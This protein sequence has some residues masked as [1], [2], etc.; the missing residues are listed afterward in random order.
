MTNM[1]YSESGLILKSHFLR[2][3]PILNLTMSVTESVDISTIRPWNT[4]VRFKK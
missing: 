4:L 2:T 1:S 3:V